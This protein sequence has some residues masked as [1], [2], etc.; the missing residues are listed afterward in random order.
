MVRP[1]AARQLRNDILACLKG[2]IEPE[3][4]RVIELNYEE[5]QEKADVLFALINKIEI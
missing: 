4:V 2:N 5:A 1:V 3:M